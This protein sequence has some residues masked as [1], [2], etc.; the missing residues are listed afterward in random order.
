MELTDLFCFSSQL[1]LLKVKRI[2][3]QA[4][5]SRDFSTFFFFLSVDK[6]A[7]DRCVSV[8]TSGRS[9]YWI[10]KSFQE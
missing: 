2:F 8:Y 1:I 10:Y 4:H 7:A 3:Q 9:Q 5:N 6:S